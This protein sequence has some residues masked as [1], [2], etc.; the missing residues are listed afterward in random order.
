[1]ERTSRDQGEPFRGCG[2]VLSE[3]GEDHR[4]SAVLERPFRVTNVRSPL[5][6]GPLKPAGVRQKN[7]CISVSIDPAKAGGSGA[8]DVTILTDHPD[9]PRVVL[10]VLVSPAKKGE[11]HDLPSNPASLHARRASWSRSGS[12]ASWSRSCSLLSSPPA[13]LHGGP[14]AKIT[15]TR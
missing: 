8:S 6:D 11:A 5:L 1:M 15:F 10:S 2:G 3:T 4:A 14:A 9:Q 7:H 13:R 12:S